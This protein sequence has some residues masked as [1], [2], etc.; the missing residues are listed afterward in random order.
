MSS[1]TQH[2]ASNAPAWTWHPGVMP[3]PPVFDEMCPPGM[4]TEEFRNKLLQALMEQPADSMSA[5]ILNL[6]A[7]NIVDKTAGLRPADADTAISKA[8][9]VL[10]ESKGVIWSM[11][12]SLFRQTHGIWPPA[13]L[14]DAMKVAQLN[15]CFGDTELWRKEE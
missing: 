7:S 4:S 6:V 12:P 2:P 10:E 5:F 14:A 9:S 15:M 1:W 13:N 11:F 3:R 8:I